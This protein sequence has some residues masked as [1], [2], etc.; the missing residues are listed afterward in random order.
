MK[1]ITVDDMVSHVNS[2]LFGAVICCK[3]SME[4]EM[5]FNLKV[6][7]QLYLNSNQVQND[8]LCVL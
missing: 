1:V 3:C 8:F 4:M 6:L 7:T 2:V 5:S